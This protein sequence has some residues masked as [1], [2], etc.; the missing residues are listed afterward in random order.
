M[1]TLFTALRAQH[2]VAIERPRQTLPSK[3]AAPQAGLSLLRVEHKHT[4][5]ALLPTQRKRRTV[6]PKRRIAVIGA[7][8][9]GLCAAYELRGLGY[10]VSVF[11][12]ANRVGGR[13]Q[14][15]SKFAKGKIAE[16]GGELIG[17]NHP[18]WNSYRQHFGLHFSDVKD[19]KK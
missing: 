6:R 17:S 7:G 5:A 4:Y 12:A 19:Y 9:A 3:E 15:L 11:E 8:L 2:G 10:E 18:L 1:P 16:G 13:V 14:S